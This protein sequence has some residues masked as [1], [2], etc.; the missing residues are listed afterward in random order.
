MMVL[1]EFK[2]LSIVRKFCFVLRPVQWQRDTLGQYAMTNIVED[3][4]C[5][6]IAE[7]WSD[8]HRRSVKSFFSMLHSLESTE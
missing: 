5:E 8:S 7:I 1:E 2:H 6:L 3:N 4:E